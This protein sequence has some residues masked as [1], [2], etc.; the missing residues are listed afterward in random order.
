MTLEELSLASITVSSGVIVFSIL[1]GIVSPLLAVTLALVIARSCE[2]I[3]YES[4]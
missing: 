2:E 3:I 4:S 1:Y